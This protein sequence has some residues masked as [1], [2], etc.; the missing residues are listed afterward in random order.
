ME[1]PIIPIY[2]LREIIDWQ[3]VQLVNPDIWAFDINS[4]NSRVVELNFPS[5]VICFGLF[6][7][8]RGEIL[9]NV[10]FQEI[11]LKKNDI[12]NL[13][14]NNIIEFKDIS[15][16]ARLKFIL[17]SIDYF[18]E[19]N[20]E[21][22]SQEAFDI[23]SNNYLKQVTLDN[24]T[25]FSI[26]YHI[27][28]IQG[29]NNPENANSFNLEMLK[30]HFSLIMYS[31]ANYTQTQS[32]K[33]EFKTSRKEDI[34]VK[35]V[36]LVGQY[37]RYHKDVQ[38]YADTIFVTRTHLTRTIKDVFNKNPKQIIEEKLIAEIKIFLMKKEFSIAEVMREFGFDD[39]TA[40]SKFF[41]KHT[42]IS[43]GFY[44]KAL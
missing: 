32:A 29:L 34:A 22:N 14:P 18:S 37:F 43:P 6:L 42:G 15:K 24:E 9:I 8:Q 13:F 23:L 16:N 10:D 3:N 44:R 33:G 11:Q 7:V 19:L 28:S 17:I 20:L 30:L 39:Q 1:K 4:S 40:F 26:I 21:I 35:F 5:K 36:S 12:V 31:L 2:T 38:Y 41:K 25:M 27:N